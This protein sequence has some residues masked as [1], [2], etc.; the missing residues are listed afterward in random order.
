MKILLFLP[1]VLFSSITLGQYISNETP[2]KFKGGNDAFM[3]YLQQVHYPYDAKANCMMGKIYVDFVID[4]LGRVDSISVVNIGYPWLDSAAINHI[5]NTSGLWSPGIDK[6]NNTVINSHFR[7]PFNFTVPNGG[8][9]D[10]TEYYHKGFKYFNKGKYDNAIEYFK[11]AIKMDAFY[12]DALINCAV[13]CIKIN[14]I[15]SACHY[16]KL[17]KSSGKSD[18]NELSTKYCTK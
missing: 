7:I 9:K 17:I 10:K 2:A 5:K 14:D 15:E 1:L 18:G 6:R 8:C 12:T 11:I 3:Q 13:S 4:T 16:L